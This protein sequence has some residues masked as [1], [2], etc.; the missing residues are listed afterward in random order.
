MTTTPRR[1]PIFAPSLIWCW[2]IDDTVDSVAA[3]PA[4]VYDATNSAKRTAAELDVELGYLTG[5]GADG[6]ITQLDV[7]QFI[8]N[9][10]P[11][12]M[13]E[14]ARPR[15]TAEIIAEMGNAH[16]RVTQEFRGA[17][18]VLY[19][20]L[21]APGETIEVKCQGLDL[22][23][24]ADVPTAI[25]MWGTPISRGGTPQRLNRMD[26]RFHILTAQAGYPW[27]RTWG[28]R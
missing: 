18:S 24:E 1:S 2:R 7:R 6:K 23:G 8:A 22:P 13:Q 17:F 15:T 26:R 20:R 14:V 27:G 5:T 12:P 28:P 11:V 19:S 16:M 10:R 9:G 21:Y 25:I 3:P 4:T